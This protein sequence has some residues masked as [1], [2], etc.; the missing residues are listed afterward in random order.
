M[1]KG[2]L[3]RHLGV[4]KRVGQGGREVYVGPKNADGLE[5]KATQEKIGREVG[6]R[7]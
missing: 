6:V 7:E 4:A 5:M 1:L 2:A 3:G